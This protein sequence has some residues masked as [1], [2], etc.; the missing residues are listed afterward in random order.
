MADFPTR[1]D[2]F[3]VARDEILMRN[4]QLTREIVE[5][6]GSDANLMLYAGVAMGDTIV[7]RLVRIVSGLYLDT[8]RGRCLDRLAWDRYGIIRKQ[9]APAIGTAVFSTTAPNPSAFTIPEGTTVA[10]ADGVEFTTT[11][12]TSFPAGSTGPIYVPIRSTQNG[13][14]QQAA[15]GTITSITSTITGQ[16]NDIA[17]TNTFATAGADDEESD[18]SLRDRCRRF[19][20][21]VQRG[22]IGAIEAAA[23]GVAGVTKAT[24]VESIDA[25]GRPNKYVQLV[26]SDRFTDALAQ[27]GTN[28]PA[29]EAQSQQLAQSVFF[30]LSNVRPAGTFVQVVVAQ[31][32]LQAIQLQLTF[33]AG[34]DVDAVA[35]RARALVANQVNQLQPGVQL[36]PSDLVDGLRTVVGLSITGN[37]VTSPA[38]DVIPSANQVIRTSLELVTA[39]AVQSSQP[40][41]LTTN[42]D[43]Y[44]AS[45][46]TTF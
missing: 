16:P 44:I 35:L 39:A 8:A 33:T 15:I 40:I 38:G 7:G 31:V 1:E 45:P 34:V 9:A 46:A 3:R 22:T 30:A 41:A 13:A 10:T 42:P 36:S 24:A 12:A 21:T 14:D 19:F 20:T 17:V 18:E 32:V 25:F 2:L 29:Y 43:A 23:L 11:L 26:V 28:D 5:R 37:E 27:L 6:P 4:G